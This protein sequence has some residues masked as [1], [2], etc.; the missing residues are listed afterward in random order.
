MLGVRAA[1]LV[2]T[3]S[4]AGTG[5]LVLAEE[6]ECQHGVVMTQH[7]LSK[8]FPTAAAA[9]GLIGVGIYAPGAAYAAEVT[10]ST[11]SSG[12]S[13]SWTFMLI[14]LVSLVGVGVAIYL[15]K[16]QKVEPP[17]PAAVTHA[18]S[19]WQDLARQASVRLVPKFVFDEIDQ[20]AHEIED[21]GGKTGVVPREKSTR[22]VRW[23]ADAGTLGKYQDKLR[24]YRQDSDFDWKRAWGKELHELAEKDLSDARLDVS[25]LMSDPG[26]KKLGAMAQKMVREAELEIERIDRHVKISEHQVA[27]E[28]DRAKRV[29]DDLD[30]KAT[31]FRK[32]Y[33][34]QLPTSST[35]RYP[36][37][38]PKVEG[39]TGGIGKSRSRKYHPRYHNNRKRPSPTAGRVADDGGFRGG[40]F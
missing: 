19:I 6:R 26:T 3:S 36:W 11:T 29:V 12:D 38:I 7:S 32:Q 17:Q 16:N 5:L 40:S 39:K 23:L 4:Y 27:K 25:T 9:L 28:E 30:A 34:S 24:Y 13:G 37:F 14:G 8:A 1:Q 22:H 18:I 20:Y 35:G 21:A 10:A 15:R 33:K 2:G 31:N